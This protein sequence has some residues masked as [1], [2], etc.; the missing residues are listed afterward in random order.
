MNWEAGL[1]GN[2][3]LSGTRPLEAALGL[4]DFVEFGTSYLPLDRVLTR[5]LL[6]RL[7]YIHENENDAIY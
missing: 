2:R 1:H 3:L 5:P 4:K 6:A 7:P